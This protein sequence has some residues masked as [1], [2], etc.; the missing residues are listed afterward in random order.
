MT[1]LPSRDPAARL[2]RCKRL[3]LRSQRGGG[4]ENIAYRITAG[5]GPC[6]LFNLRHR[7]GLPKSSQLR[8]VP[9][10]SEIPSKIRKS[11]C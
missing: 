11:I 6:D 3:R 9:N 4:V 5:Q 7:I 1:G 8:N 2:H 10:F